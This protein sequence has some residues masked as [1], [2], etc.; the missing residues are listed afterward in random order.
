MSSLVNQVAHLFEKNHQ[1]GVSRHAW[2]KAH[3]GL[4]RMCP[5][6]VSWESYHRYRQASIHAVTWLR[7]RY[8]IRQIREI[9]T[10]M[11]RTYFD[12]RRAAGVRPNTLATDVSAVRRLGLYAVLEK[13]QP[14]NFVPDDLTAGR[15]SAPRFAYPPEYAAAVIAYVAERDRLAADVLI[16]QDRGGLRIDE[17]VMTR[18]DQIDFE[19]GT[20]TVKGKGGQQR[21]SVITD[22]AIVDRL[23]RVKWPLLRGKR[24]AWIRRIEALVRKAC[25]SLGFE[26]LGTHALRAADAQRTYDAE[27]EAGVGD[28]AARQ[29]VAERLGHHRTDV[30]HSYVP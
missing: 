24:L 17:A 27:I 16:V 1:P 6:T 29:T 3:P 30:T 13:W 19:Q 8:H 2:R 10:A 14:A 7:E 20:I 28:R 18:I 26:P 25:L 15:E 4:G 21:T 23:Q 5:F 22:R 12:E 11:I 9:T